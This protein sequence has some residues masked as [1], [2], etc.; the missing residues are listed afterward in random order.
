M[1]PRTTLILLAILAI[2]GGYVYF[3]ELRQP[4]TSD[5]ETTPT[6]APAWSYPIDQI[7]G[8]AIQGSGKQTRLT[9]PAGGAWQMEAPQQGAVDNDR[10]TAVVDSLGT[11]QVSRTLTDTTNSLADYGLAQPALQVTVRLAD[12]SDH[13]LEIGNATPTQ[14]DY[15]VQVQGQA[16]IHLLSASVVQSLQDLLDQP[17]FPPTPTPTEPATPGAAS[18]QAATPAPTSTQPATPAPTPTA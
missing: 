11:L 13:A 12:G 7:V 9:R 6:P 15:Y 4:A 14:T 16:P 1:K 10:V 18:A 2:L 3:A 8:L 17:P 5:T